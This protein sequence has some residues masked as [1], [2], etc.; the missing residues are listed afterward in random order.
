MT[1]IAIWSGRCCRDVN[2]MVPGTSYAGL[3]RE[4]LVKKTVNAPDQSSLFNNASQA[5]NHAFYWRSL[6]P[7]AS[8]TP[9]AKLQAKIAAS[10]GDVQ[11]LKKE[12]AAAATTQFGVGLGL[13]GG[14]GR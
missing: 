1:A 2:K 14:R 12:L 8:A 7:K 9:P 3:S 11:S 4:D 5:W 13:A 6:S 10:F